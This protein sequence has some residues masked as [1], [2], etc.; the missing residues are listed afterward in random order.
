[1]RASLLCLLLF[2]IGCS[3]LH[4]QQRPVVPRAQP[5]NAYEPV[6]DVP[7]LP[8]VLLIGD[9]ISEGYTLPV[10]RLLQGRANVHRI[11][12]NGGPAKTAVAKIGQWLGTAKWD[13]IHF[14]WGLHDLM[15]FPSTTTEPAQH[16]SEQLAL[17]EKNLR[18]LVTTLKHTGA[19][20]IWATST[21]VPDEMTSPRSPPNR[22][23]VVKR[24]NNIAAQ[25][26]KEN[27]V[28]VDDLNAHAAPV[29]AAMQKPH[30]VHFSTEGSE[31]LAKKVAEEIGA[32]LRAGSGSNLK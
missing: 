12:E 3:G 11:P 14:N 21:P 16:E 6:V 31:F 29:L 1:M 2:A 25:V 27:D 17:Y 13:V 9:S 24:Y 15:F 4:A 19:R 23:A 26:M 20:L 32:A 28:P 10:R 5:G 7:G 22:S 8:R 30:D 18:A